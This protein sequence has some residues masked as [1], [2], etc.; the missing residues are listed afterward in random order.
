VSSW[1]RHIKLNAVA[2]SAFNK[3]G[4]TW[5][6][7]KMKRTREIGNVKQK[8]STN[9]ASHRRHAIFFPRSDG[10]LPSLPPPAEPDGGFRDAPSQDIFLRLRPVHPP[11]PRSPL[12]LHIPKPQPPLLLDRALGPQ[13][14]RPLGGVSGIDEA[15]GDRRP[16][17][18]ARHVAGGRRDAAGAGRAP[19]RCAAARL[20]F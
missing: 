9:Q 3:N 19:P 4:A 2:V 14:P 11:P 10:A 13:P 18:G 17:G 5:F 6:L 15:P 7:K 16:H 20:R 1:C 12:L 8:N